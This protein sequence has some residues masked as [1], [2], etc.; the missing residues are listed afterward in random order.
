MADG[1]EVWVKIDTLEIIYG[2]IPQREIVETLVWAKVQQ[3][4]L[5]AK[6]E[7]LQE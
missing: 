5:L 3:S 1:R 2:K 7:A 4:F 6:F